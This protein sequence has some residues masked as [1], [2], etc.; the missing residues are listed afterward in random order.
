MKPIHLNP[1]PRLRYAAFELLRYDFD[2]Y[3]TASV[4]PF[5]SYVIPELKRNIPQ[6]PAPCIGADGY[7]T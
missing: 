5:T 6:F 1:F 3:T 4:T 7:P 2:V